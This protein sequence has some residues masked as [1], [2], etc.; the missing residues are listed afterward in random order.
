[1]SAEKYQRLKELSKQVKPFNGDDPEDEERSEINQEFFILCTGILPV[2][3]DRLEYYLEL[4]NH[5]VDEAVE[6]LGG[7]DVEALFG[8]PLGNERQNKNHL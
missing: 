3:I 2:L 6:M 5:T 4:D 7:W 1:M 8:E